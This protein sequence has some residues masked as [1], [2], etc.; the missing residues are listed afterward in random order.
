MR[1][2]WA[3]LCQ[4]SVIDRTTNNL[5]IFN[6]IEELQVVGPVP[7][8]E[9]GDPTPET[10]TPNLYELVILFSRTDFEVPERGRGRVRA[11]APDGT[12]AHPQEFEIDLS[13]F[14]R[15]RMQVK[16]PG[17]PIRGEGIYKFIVDYA[18]EGDGWSVPYELP[19][20]VTLLSQNSR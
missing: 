3:I 9:A 4:S 6:V 17:I 1:V 8:G 13:Q 2:V 12:A 7:E 20:R 18:T 19:L 10:V 15:L 16:I 14:L 11:M 5:S